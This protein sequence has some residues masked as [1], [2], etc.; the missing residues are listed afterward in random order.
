[1][2]PYARIQ[3]HNII[4]L[5]SALPFYVPLIID[6]TLQTLPYTALVEHIGQIK[7]VALLSYFVIDISLCQWEHMTHLL[8]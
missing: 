2:D 8:L 5:R 6:S 3:G 4:D 7:L 1:M